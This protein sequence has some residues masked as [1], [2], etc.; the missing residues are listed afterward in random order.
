MEKRVAFLFGSI[1]GL[2]RALQD[3]DAC[4]I[5]YRQGVVLLLVH[6]AGALDVAAFPFRPVDEFGM[7]S[8]AAVG[9]GQHDGDSSGDIVVA[10]L[11]DGI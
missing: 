3:V 7:E 2:D 9:A 11:R 5:V 4:V 10:G 8:S 1:A 6:D